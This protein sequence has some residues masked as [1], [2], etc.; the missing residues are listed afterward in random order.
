MGAYIR[1]ALGGAH[2]TL[3]VMGLTITDPSR[4]RT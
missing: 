4:D 1:E 3:G 2:M